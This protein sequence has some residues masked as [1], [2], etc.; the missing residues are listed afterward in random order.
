MR[1]IFL[2]VAALALV[3]AGL[4]WGYPRV[5]QW[6]ALD[7]PLARAIDQ[8]DLEA[9][10][11]LV[12]HGAST[13]VRGRGGSGF[14]PFLD[15]GYRTALMVAA[16]RGELELVKL[17][18]SR[19]AEVNARDGNGGTPLMYACE[20]SAEPE[21]VE[22]LLAAGADVNARDDQRKTTLM[23]MT[24][25]TTDPPDADRI[26]VAE[27]LVEAG[28]DV[29]AMCGDETALA[30]AERNGCREVEQVLRKAGARGLSEELAGV[31]GA[32]LLRAVETA[33]LKEVARLLR[34][35]HRLDVRNQ[36]GLT[37]LLIVT[38]DGRHVALLQLI[39]KF[40]QARGAEVLNAA[41]EYGQTALHLAVSRY[42]PLYVGPLVRA[43]ADPRRR[44]DDGETPLGIAEEQGRR[45]MS[46]C[47]DALR[48]AEAARAP[49]AAPQGTISK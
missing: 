23:R 13:R 41:D 30:M 2:F 17:L 20:W 27:L 19:G 22:A 5:Y 7:R 46:K 11:R 33:N 48:A 25:L 8:R 18:L 9:I 34:A 32:E 26:R 4:R 47:L 36:D 1:R 35:G 6:F 28:A 14:S 10:G 3:I 21:V 12:E 40:P 49:D 45:G 37:P 38:Q 16:Q 44:N 24:T 29:N 43:G 39:L 31:E 15:P 42:N